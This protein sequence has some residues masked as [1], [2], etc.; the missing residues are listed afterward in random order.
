[1][2]KSFHFDSTAYDIGLKKAE[3]WAEE[4]NQIVV[5]EMVE[6]TTIGVETNLRY[7]IDVPVPIPVV[8]VGSVI[9]S[10]SKLHSEN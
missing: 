10:D 6:K 8:L 2:D 5:P 9:N 3:E 1:M 7:G 4:F